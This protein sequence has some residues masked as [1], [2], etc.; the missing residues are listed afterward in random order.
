VYPS[1]LTIC[2][3]GG[4]RSQGGRS[5]KRLFTASIGV[6]VELKLATESESKQYPSHA[7]SSINPFA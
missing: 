1:R 6:S 7:V 5:A 4:T 2:G 3:M